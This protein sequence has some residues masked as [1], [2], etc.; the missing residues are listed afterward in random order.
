MGFQLFASWPRQARAYTHHTCHLMPWCSFVRC[1]CIF[2]IFS[3]KN[4]PVQSVII[5]LGII[6]A[7]LTVLKTFNTKWFST[8][9]LFG[10]S[11]SKSICIILAVSRLSDHLLSFLTVCWLPFLSKTIPPSALYFLSVYLPIHTASKSQSLEASSCL[12]GN[13]EAK[14]IHRGKQQL[15]VLCLPRGSAIKRDDLK[16]KTQCDA[17]ERSTE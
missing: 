8:F 1:L 13:R 16:A 4:H 9:S 14:S 15:I 10:P 6:V 7:L 5:F 12:G 11:E 17:R 3:T 2:Y